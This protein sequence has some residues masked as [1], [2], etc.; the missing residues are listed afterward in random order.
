VVL[1]FP[2]VPTTASSLTVPV[3]RILL[4]SSGYDAATCLM[5]LRE[6]RGCSCADEAQGA[7]AKTLAETAT[8]KVLWKGRIGS[9]N[10]Y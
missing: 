5:I 1:T 9:L 3:M 8:T 4:A 7:N 10:A 2:L 6:T